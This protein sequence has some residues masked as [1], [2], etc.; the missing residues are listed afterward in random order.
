M[1]GGG[2]DYEKSIE[3]Y[4]NIPNLTH[5]HGTRIVEDIWLNM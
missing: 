1:L 3:L 4:K 5:V 2:V